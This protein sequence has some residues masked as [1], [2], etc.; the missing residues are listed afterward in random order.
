MPAFSRPFKSHR[1]SP[2]GVRCS[3]R[4]TLSTIQLST[5]SAIRNI[6]PHSS[7]NSHRCH[8][9]INQHLVATTFRRHPVLPLC[10]KR[11]RFQRKLTITTRACALLLENGITATEH[12]IRL[13]TKHDDANQTKTKK[14]KF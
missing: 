12:V 1:L 5:A 14:K 7:R 9:L 4:P 8:A 3:P 13:Y 11:N 10:P 2:F 6:V